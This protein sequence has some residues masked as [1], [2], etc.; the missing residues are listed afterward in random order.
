[1]KIDKKKNKTHKRDKEKHYQ[2][3]S[4]TFGEK[5]DN[6]YRRYINFI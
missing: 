1:M 5:R 2:I 6:Q 3:R 4:K